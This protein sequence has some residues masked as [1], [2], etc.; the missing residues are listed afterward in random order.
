MIER[1][2]A[3]PAHL[4]GTLIVG[5]GVLFISFDSLLI[6]LAHTDSWNIIFWRGLLMTVALMIWF[7]AKERSQAL[8]R[9]TDCFTTAALLAILMLGAN[10]ALFVLSISLTSV[11]NTLVILTSAPLFAA[12]FSLIFLHERVHLNTWLTIF[13]AALGVVVV[14]VGSMESERHWGDLL[15]LL[16]AVMN[17]AYLTLFRRHNNLPRTPLVAV[18][19]MVTAFIAAP[20]SAPF[21]LEASSYLVLAIMGLIQVPV[22][23]VLITTGTRFLPAPEVSLFLLVET[24]LGPIWVWIAIGE[25]VPDNTWIGG[26]II[27]TALT[28]HSWYGLRTIKQKT[29]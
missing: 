22:A 9:L 23:M 1:I 10:S 18:S 4:Q 12:L 14:F 5:T 13:A 11:A 24:L 27:L 28:L 8:K 20:L 6:R 26:S 21:S 19:G 17:G 29:P 2:Q 7:V 25:R 3:L 15:A 16:T